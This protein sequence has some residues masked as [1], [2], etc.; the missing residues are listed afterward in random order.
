MRRKLEIIYWESFLGAFNLIKKIYS[1]ARI[2]SWNFTAFEALTPLNL[3]ST[4][5][6]KTL[7]QWTFCPL[8]RKKNL[9]LPSSLI[10][11]QNLRLAL[12][13]NKNFPRI[14]LL[15]N[16]NDFQFYTDKLL[17]RHLSKWLFDGMRRHSSSLKKWQ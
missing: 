5:K 16:Q 15:F 17:G 12:G 4:S 11:V 10:L 8:Q 14:L 3:S 6:Q 13:D 1:F 7:R 2:T 9:F